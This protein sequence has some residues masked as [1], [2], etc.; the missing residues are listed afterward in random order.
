MRRLAALA[1]LALV[2]VPLARADGDPASDYMLAVDVF[3]PFDGKISAARGAQVTALVA[4]A[5]QRGFPLKVALIVTR[6]DLGSVP[7]LWLHPHEYARFLG[8][9]DFFAFKTRLLV[10]M[11]NGYG[12]SERGKTLARA[13][14]LTDKLPKPGTSGDA[15][16]VAAERAVTKLAAQSGVTL[17]LPP[18]RAPATSSTTN[19]DRLVILAAVLGV[20]GLA[21][22][23]YVI[24]RLF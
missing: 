12:V 3:V 21:G 17:T 10:V 2:V 4:E 16:A 18:L 1:A 15:I 23:A 13:Q 20:A 14:A 9:E 6:Y 11:P 22:I 8:Q 7:S 24:R 19:R 5:K